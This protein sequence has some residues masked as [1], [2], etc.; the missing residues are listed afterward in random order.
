MDRPARADQDAACSEAS[1]NNNNNNKTLFNTQDFAGQLERAR[2]T[3]KRMTDALQTISDAQRFG[4]AV[5]ITSVLEYGCATGI[6]TRVA[7]QALP[8]ARVIG[9][10]VDE[11]AIAIARAN[12]SD[13][14]QF[15]LASEL[16]DR[17]AD[18]VLCQH[19]FTVQTADEL[20]SKVAA[21]LHFVNPHGL[22]WIV[23]KKEANKQA[24]DEYVARLPPTEYVYIL[25]GVRPK[26][27]HTQSKRKQRDA[28]L[29]LLLSRRGAR[30]LLH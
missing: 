17:T 28:Y 21:L 26:A 23:F 11:E 16:G 8:R 1:S 29:Y 12:A 25:H 20:E 18:L 2:A 5:N 15:Y 27:N 30:S 4:Q 10:D 19:V 24:V 13:G 14:V 3:T 22:L 7:K 6:T 9:F